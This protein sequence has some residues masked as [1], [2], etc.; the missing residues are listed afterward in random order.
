MISYLPFI[1]VGATLSIVLS[2]TWFVI[3]KCKKTV[4]N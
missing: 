3:Q 4:N 2:I 1:I